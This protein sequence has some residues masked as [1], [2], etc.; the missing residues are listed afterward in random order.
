MGGD[1]QP[2]VLTR[3]GRRCRCQVV[4]SGDRPEL[5]GKSR[6]NVVRAPT[7]LIVGGADIGVIE[8]NEQAFARLQRQRR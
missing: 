1:R 4:S 8:L 5:V 6:L 7:L 3:R 2:H